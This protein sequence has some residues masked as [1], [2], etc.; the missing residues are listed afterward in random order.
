MNN[1]QGID[2]SSLTLVIL[3]NY[4]FHLAALAIESGLEVLA[5]TMQPETCLVYS[6][7]NVDLGLMLAPWSQS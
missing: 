4:S 2:G 7:W 6:G 5:T 1:V 3:S